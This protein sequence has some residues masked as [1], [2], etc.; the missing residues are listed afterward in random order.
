MISLISG[1]L[2]T[3]DLDRVE[4]MTASGVGYEIEIPLGVFESH[5]TVEL[6]MDGAAWE[7]MLNQ[8]IAGSKVQKKVVPV[9]AT[10]FASSFRR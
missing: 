10:D 8:L 5:E 7:K 9:E 1:T 4:V 3:K 6:P 2:V